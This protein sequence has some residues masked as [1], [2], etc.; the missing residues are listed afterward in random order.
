MAEEQWIYTTK[1]EML[2]TERKALSDALA[3]AYKAMQGL[4]SG[5]IQS[6]NLGHYSISRTKLDL[7]KLQNW[8]NAT[9]IRIDE[10][11]CMLTGRSVRKVSTCVYTN[12]QNT[13]GWL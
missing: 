13:W 2:I 10:I 4:M 1:R 8:I 7:D 3:D 12:P 6:Y 5:E 9:R 11:D